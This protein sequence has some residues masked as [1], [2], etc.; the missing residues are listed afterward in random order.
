MA[1]TSLL[2]PFHTKHAVSM[3]FVAQDLPHVDHML[4]VIPAADDDIIHPGKG[5]LAVANGSVHVPLEG[6]SRV[7]QTKRHPLILEQAE[8]RGD[9]GL[10]YI[11]WIH[12]DLVVPFLRPILEKT[13]Q[14]AALAGKSSMSGSGYTSGSVTKINILNSSDFVLQI[15]V[16]IFSIYLCIVYA[17][18]FLAQW[19]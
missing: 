14:P 18:I 15:F 16:Y 1:A 10:L 6:W 11:C 9:G 3:R 5:G 4:L 13:V 8:G 2:T 12:G 19:F 7:P 17:P